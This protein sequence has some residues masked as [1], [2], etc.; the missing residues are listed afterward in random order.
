M[1]EL[2][3]PCWRRACQSFCFFPAFPK[4]HLSLNSPAASI[5][6]LKKISYYSFLQS[7]HVREIFFCFGIVGLISL[8]H[9]DFCL[10]I[11][12][13]SGLTSSHRKNPYSLL[14]ISYYSIPTV[15][16]FLL[17][18]VTNGNYIIHL[19][20]YWFPPSLLECMNFKCRAWSFFLM[21]KFH[22]YWVQ[23]CSACCTTGQ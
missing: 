18:L 13:Q 20:D 19:L 12:F 1:G 22:C 8:Y 3:L 23:A 5:L 17:L 9:L 14:S 4:R 11:T 6:S 15:F 2:T 16:F 10:N 21:T 7:T